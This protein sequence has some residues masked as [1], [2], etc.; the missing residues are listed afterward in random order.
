LRADGLLAVLR[1]ALLHE[2]LEHVLLDLLLH[3]TAAPR[4]LRNL[5]EQDMLLALRG[6][7]PGHCCGKAH[8]RRAGSRPR[9]ER[10]SSKRQRMVMMR[11][12]EEGGSE[13]QQPTWHSMSPRNDD[14]DDDDVRRQ[15]KESG[16]GE[17][18]G[19]RDD[20]EGR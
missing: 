2:L 4:R 9:G 3:R 12:R 14:D 10:L 8:A 20:D 17:R 18:R 19:K 15:G 5:L 16:G 13:S 1:G 7:L 11:R 6:L